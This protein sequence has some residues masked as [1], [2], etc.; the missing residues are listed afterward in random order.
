[1]KVKYG[2]IITNSRGKLGGQYYSRNHYGPFAAN[3]VTPTNP[4][5][6]YQSTARSTFLFF[7]QKWKTLSIDDQLRWTEAAVNFPKTDVFGDEYFSTGKNLY[8]SLNINLSIIGQTAISTPPS[9]EVI[10]PIPSIYALTA[11]QLYGYIQLE[12]TD[13]FTDT[14]QYYIVRA[15]PL[16]SPGINVVTSKLTRIFVQDCDNSNVWDWGAPWSAK[17]GALT[18]GNRL[19]IEVQSIQK[20]SGQAGIP[21]RTSCIISA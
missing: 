19:F 5:T 1:M 18:A 8:V 10:T 11:N 15:T 13:D 3:I 7:N 6:S 4:Q 9:P 14:N 21:R 12:L 2:S 17:F 20:H 16:L